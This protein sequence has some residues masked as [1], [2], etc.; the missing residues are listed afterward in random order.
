[1]AAG[2]RSV[3]PDAVIDCCPVGDGGE[4]TLA[5]LLEAA[6]WRRVSITAAG[7]FGDEVDACIGLLAEGNLAYVE[8][9]AVIGLGAIS[10][11]QRNVM[12]ASSFGVGEL[13]LR[14]AEYSPARIVVGIGGSATNDGGCGMAQAL[15]VRFYDASNK[16]IHTPISGASI[17]GI[18]RVD[19]SQRSSLI[20]NIPIDVACDVRNPLTGPD[21]AAF[22]YGP[23]KGAS[24]AQVQQL[25]DG[26][27]NVASVISK[28]LGIDIS[29]LPGAGAAGGLGAG[30]V[31]FAGATLVSGIDTIL[32]AVRFSSRVEDA[33]LCLTGEGK[34]DA[35][36]L[37]GKACI[38]V[39]RAAARAGVATIALVGSAGPDANRCLEAGISEYVVI[40]EGLTE[41]ESMRQARELLIRAAAKVAERYRPA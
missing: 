11:D 33:N 1:M 40:S 16:L 2:L 14:A 5:A 35:Q 17:A 30:L 20:A 34:L 23:Q 12:A 25:D 31:A 13:I 29:V 24:P 3:I 4:G 27:A 38:G 22:V 6:A 26:L 19:V 41:Q 21:G 28:D 18:S 7:V 8:S 10:T 15:G 9:A 39:A 37:S 36:S 32:D